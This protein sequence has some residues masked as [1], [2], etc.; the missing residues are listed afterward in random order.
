MG[1]WRELKFH[2]RPISKGEYGKLSKVREELEEAED[3]EEQEQLL[4]LL[5]ELSDIVGA[6]KGVAESYDFPF[7]EIVKNAELRCRVERDAQR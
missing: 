4:M 6:V 3:A 1:E 5:I 7:E 2:E